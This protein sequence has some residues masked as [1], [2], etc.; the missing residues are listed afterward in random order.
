M[1]ADFTNAIK[2][3]NKA[4]YAAVIPDIKCLSPKEGDLLR[5]RCPVET[6]RFLVKSG[7]KALSVVTESANFGGSPQLLSNIA[8]A[9]GV[10]ILRKD[11]FTKPEE[12]EECVKIG[13]NAVLLICACIDEKTLRLLYK[14]AL[15]LGLE[16]L[17]E[18]CN[19]DEMNLAR[20]LGAKLV[21][22]NN[23]NIVTLEL[24][25]GGAERTAGLA[26]LAPKSA[27]LI[28]ESGIQ[29]GN[30]ARLAV[31]AGANAVLVG[32]ALWQSKDMGALLE[33]LRVEI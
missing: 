1:T 13:A 16:P 6:A 17:V 10:P 33:E 23:R 14:E 15:A 26:A 18:V 2:T 32:T 8:K 7:A 12:L 27:V 20:D 3:E 30:D 29:N 4:G 9:T 25:S 22:I 19:R 31:S 5:G 21:G 24:D 28:S 11:F